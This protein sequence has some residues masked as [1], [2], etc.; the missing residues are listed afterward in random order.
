M[1]FVEWN[2]GVEC[3][4]LP[5]LI[6]NVPPFT[7]SID[8]FPLQLIHRHLPFSQK[9]CPKSVPDSGIFGVEWW[10]GV[11]SRFWSRKKLVSDYLY[12][13]NVIMTN[14]YIVT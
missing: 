2:L 5:P 4:Q 3:G 7:I 11:W 14:T 6:L 10:S 9:V 12:S 1:Y 8:T 13:Y